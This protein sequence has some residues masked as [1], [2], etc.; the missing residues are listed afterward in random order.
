VAG[1]SFVRYF[2][3]ASGR[4]AKIVDESGGVT[5]RFFDAKSGASSER[6][7]APERSGDHAHEERLQGARGLRGR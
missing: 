2:G 6:W 7:E 3:D 5:E 4:G 1:A